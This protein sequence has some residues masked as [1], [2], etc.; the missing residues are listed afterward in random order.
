MNLADALVPKQYSDGEQIIKQ[1]DTADGMYFV[2]DGVVRITIIGDH[3]REIEVRQLVDFHFP[4]CHII[5]TIIDIH[6]SVQHE[7]DTIVT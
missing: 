3:G 2:E 7:V 6:S 4:A 5:A 1:G